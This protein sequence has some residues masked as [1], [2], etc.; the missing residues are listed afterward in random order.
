[1]NKIALFIAIFSSFSLFAQVYGE[2]EI[3]LKSTDIAA[4][5]VKAPEGIT[6]SPEGTLYTTSMITGK[7]YFVRPNS[8]KL[9]LAIDLAKFKSWETNSLALGIIAESEDQLWVGVTNVKGGCIVSLRRKLEAFKAKTV[10]CGAGDVNGFV[11]DKF[12]KV[13]Y[14]SS[15]VPGLSTDGMIMKIA[16]EDLKK[17]A[18]TNSELQYDEEKHELIKADMP[19][20]IVLSRSRTKLLFSQTMKDTVSIVDLVTKKVKV[21][22]ESKQDGWLDGL[23]Y[24]SSHKMYAVSDSKLGRIHF[25]DESGIDIK[26]VLLN[27]HEGKLAGPASLVISRGELYFTD[28]WTGSLVNKVLEQV[29][30]DNSMVNYHQSIYK[31]SLSE[32]LKFP[33]PSKLIIH[34]K[35]SKASLSPLFLY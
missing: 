1:M 4:N 23:V 29:T 18:D 6:I 20:G 25:F 34:E 33:E 26:S 30:G 35:P 11:I 22:F 17:A 27:N 15:R 32:I 31:L 12:N 16:L 8:K 24:L 9:E 21:I 14:A 2:M 13:L 5:D 7:I 10:L 19:N 28:A 3:N